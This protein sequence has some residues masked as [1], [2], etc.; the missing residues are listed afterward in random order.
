[1]LLNASVDISALRLVAE[2]GFCR[3]E[4]A[5]SDR[6]SLVAN[7]NRILRAGG[8]SVDGTNGDRA[9]AAVA[10]GLRRRI[11]NSAIGGRLIGG[12]MRNFG[13]FYLQFHR[14]HALL[15]FLHLLVLQLDLSRL[16]LD[17]LAELL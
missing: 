5:G 2:H 3:Q 17:E 1:M 13:G 14:L 10:D 16:R 12:V 9:G 11:R 4:T 7:R 6:D 15:L 8:L